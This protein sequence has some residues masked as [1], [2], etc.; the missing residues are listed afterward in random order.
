MM[1]TLL[2]VMMAASCG[3]EDE[4]IDPVESAPYA[5]DTKSAT[6]TKNTVEAKSSAAATE[7][8][9]VDKWPDSTDLETAFQYDINTGKTKP[10]DIVSFANTLMGTPYRYGSIDPFVGFDCSG[11]ITYVFGHFNIKVPRSSV[12]FTDVGREIPETE[13]KP[14]DII[15]FTGTNADDRRVGHMG[16]V[17]KAFSEGDLEFIHSSSGKAYG[18]TLSNLTSHYRVR[19]VKVIRIFSQ[20]DRG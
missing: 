14:G 16:I 8:A 12:D 7:L 15:L 1:K 3:Q 9:G 10:Q 5:V 4:N 2:L 11:F 17:N 18:V 6:D 20:N 19:F 13:A